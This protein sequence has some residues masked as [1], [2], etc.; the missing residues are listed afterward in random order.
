MRTRTPLSALTRAR[1]MHEMTGQTTSSI[2]MKRTILITGGASGIGLAT[3]RHFA[4]SGYRVM[5]ADRNPET[6]NIAQTLRGAHGRVVDVANEN[7]LLA[8]VAWVRELSGACD[9]LVNCAGITLKSNGGPIPLE[10]LSTDDWE[11]VH[12]INLTAPFI[13]CREILPQMKQQGFGRVIN[14]AS[15]A[16]RMYVPVSGFDYHSSKTALLGLSRSLAG[17]YGPYGITV[18]SIAPGRIATPLSKAT[19]PELLAEALRQIP[20]GRFGEPEEIAGVIGFLAS[21]AGSYIN[22]AC[23][24][25]NGGIFMT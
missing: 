5:I 7:E 12:R 21:D 2:K 3:A 14:I 4:D 22:G 18:N 1:L 19:R 20:A 17:A 10:E 24:D 23:L 15:R 6:A 8:L 16:A 13:L 25:V 11:R 9:V